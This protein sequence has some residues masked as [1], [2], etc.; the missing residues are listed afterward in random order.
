[1]KDRVDQGE[2]ACPNEKFRLQWLKSGFY[3]NPAFYEYFEKKYGAIF[4]ASLYLSL[5]SDGYPRSSLNDPLR[6]LAGRHLFLGLY[7]G[8]EW[9]IKEA[10]LHKADAAIMGELNP[11]QRVT[12]SNQL[13]YKQAYEAAGIP[14]CVISTFWDADKIKAE[15]SKFIETRLLS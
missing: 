3:G 4:V 8:P 1:V 12:H 14:L 5:A 15:V 13:I 10:H 6:A 2:A 9:D 11:C 7:H